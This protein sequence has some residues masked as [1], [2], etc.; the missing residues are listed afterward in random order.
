MKDFSYIFNA[1]PSYIESIYK[2]Y[3][4]NPTDVEPEWRL[5]FEGFDFAANGNGHAPTDVSVTTVD[6]ISKEFGVMSII[7]G[8]RQRGHLL[9]TTNPIKERKN[10]MPHLDLSDYNL[11]ESD[12]DLV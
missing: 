5:F 8:F 3:Q 10:R 9:S 6:S 1:H 2:N 11:S 12:L 7:H 4:N